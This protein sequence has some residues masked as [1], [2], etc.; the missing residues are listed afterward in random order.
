MK[1]NKIRQNG[2]DDKLYSIS[3]HII[4]PNELLE[5][6][7]LE[8]EEY[9]LLNLDTDYKDYSDYPYNDES[10]YDSEEENERQLECAIEWFIDMGSHW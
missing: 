1:K 4:K 10:Y 7:D 2:Y 8:I 3:Q 9:Y 5:N 6:K